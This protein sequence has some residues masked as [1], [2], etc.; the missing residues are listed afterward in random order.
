MNT[1]PR[2][3]TAVR[4]SSVM[5]LI[6]KAFKTHEIIKTIMRAFTDEKNATLAESRKS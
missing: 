1:D 4:L 2:F 3:P 6:I 5:Y